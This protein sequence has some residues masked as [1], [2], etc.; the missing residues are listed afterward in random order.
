MM[1]PSGFSVVELLVGLVLVSVIVALSSRVF[2]VQLRSMERVLRRTEGDQAAALAWSVLGAEV[3][4]SS[5][6]VS[7]AVGPGDSVRVR[8]HRGSAWPCP[9]DAPGVLRVTYTGDRLPKPGADSVAALGDD[10]VWRAYPL[11]GVTS[12]GHC[13]ALGAPVQQWSVGGIPSTVHYLRLFESG[14]YSVERGALRYR[15][16]QGG[17]QPVSAER[18]DTASTLATASAVTG[19]VA[20]DLTIVGDAFVPTFHAGRRVARPRR[21][22][23]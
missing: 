6:A 18:F 14:T 16:G 5:E 17:R 23:P 11:T 4:A 12:G 22:L 3:R 2:V 13:A 20:V 19:G 1:R 7:A 15:L 21:S 10:G 8:A 9:G